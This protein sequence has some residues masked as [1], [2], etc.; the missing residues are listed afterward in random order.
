QRNAK[1]QRTTLFF[2][3]CHLT[4]IPFVGQASFFCQEGVS[5]MGFPIRLSLSSG[6]LSWADVGRDVDQFRQSTLM[7]LAYGSAALA[8]V[9]LGILLEAQRLVPELGLLLAAITLAALYIV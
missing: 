8:W 7:N 2:S 1:A 9:Y 4:C 3:L 5:T 6:S